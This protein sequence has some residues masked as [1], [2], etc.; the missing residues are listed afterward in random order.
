MSFI[1]FLGVVYNRA[2]GQPFVEKRQ[3]LRSIPKKQVFH[4]FN[5]H[6]SINKRRPLIYI[7]GYAFEEDLYVQAKSTYYL[8]SLE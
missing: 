5:A 3:H 4:T 6:G 1:I 2:E 8:L 7:Q